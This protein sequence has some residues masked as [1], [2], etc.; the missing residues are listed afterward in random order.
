MIQ[1]VDA[2]GNLSGIVQIRNPFYATPPAVT[3]EAPPIGLTPDGTGTVV[4]NV[5]D[6][7]GLEFFTIF[8]EAGNDVTC[9]DTG[10]T[11]SLAIRLS[12]FVT[13][14]NNNPYILIHFIMLPCGIDSYIF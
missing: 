14:A 12:D 4:D 8:T 13:E 11:S 1:A 7:D 3:V 2:D 9:P 10:L 5:A 6:E